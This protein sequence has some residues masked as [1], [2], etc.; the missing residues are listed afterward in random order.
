MDD[1][2]DW[3]LAPSGDIYGARAV[4]LDPANPSACYLGARN[5]A[6]VGVTPQQSESPP[7]LIGNNTY[8]YLLAEAGTNFKVPAYGAGRFV[9]WDVDPNFGGQIKPNDFMI[10]SDS[11]YAR[12]ASPFGPWNQWILAISVSFANSGQSC[13]CKIVGPFPWN[14]TGS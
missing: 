14:P 7:G 3:N 1:D 11:G 9:L 4:M 2:F 12:K 8:P 6:C 13:N 10:C 5:A